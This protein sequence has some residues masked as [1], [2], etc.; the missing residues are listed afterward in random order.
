MI[1]NHKKI[2]MLAITPTFYPMMGGAERASHE[3]YSRLTKKGYEIDVVTPNLEGKKKEFLLGYHIYRVGNKTNNRILKFILYQYA[4]YKKVKE[5]LKKK[6]YDLIQVTYA[7]PAFFLIRWLKK[8][9]KIPLMI[10]EHHYGAGM[11]VSSAEENPVLINYLAKKAFL[12]SDK[13][14]VIGKA[15]EDYV[16]A[17]T[18]K[19]E[20]IIIC[21]GVGKEFNP[22]KYDE[23]I[24]NKYKAYNG[25]IITVGR[26]NKRKNIDDLVKAANIVV[27]KIPK[28]K[29][30]II[31]KGKEKEHLEKLIKKFGLGKNV[32][33]TGFVSNKELPSYYATAD[34]FVLTSKYESF[35]IVYVE[36]MASGTPAIGYEMI[37]S[38]EVIE[39][40]KSGFVIKPNP[41]TLAKEIIIILKNKKKLKKMSNYAVTYVKQKF[42][43]S[44]NANEYDIEIKKLLNH[45]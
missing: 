7:V 21:G 6:D 26:L 3:L 2:K 28:I 44:K 12:L 11:D 45:K 4:Q 13:T 20:A 30:L 31:G 33:L 32:A 23:K 15:Q 10:I 8:T 37:A 18:K 41:K 29:F 5:L 24:K 14:I 36:A 9:K 19:K 43:W 38:R 27:K 39:D 1:D 17:L 34:L 40:G 35:G 42:S 16:N 22:K 25:L